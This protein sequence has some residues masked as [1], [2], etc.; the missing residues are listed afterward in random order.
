MNHLS[1]DIEALGTQPGSVILSIGL[2]LFDPLD[3]NSQEVMIEN[4]HEIFFDTAEQTELGL[5]VDVS[6]VIWWMR[7]DVTARKH[8]FEEVHQKYHLGA[9]SDYISRLLTEHQVSNVWANGPAFDMV[10][11]E[12]AF[13][14]AKVNCPWK[15]N[16]GRD[17]RTLSTLTGK[18]PTVHGI[19]HNALHDAAAQGQFVQDCYAALKIGV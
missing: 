6:T 19:A 2:V 11:L 4:G 5:K 15:Y 9:V 1:L 16:W 13:R 8:Q 12:E 3:S 14:R 10:L 18:K 17:I 7:Q